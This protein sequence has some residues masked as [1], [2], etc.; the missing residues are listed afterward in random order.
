MG[1]GDLTILIANL[2]YHPPGLTVSPVQE[3]FRWEMLRQEVPALL[4]GCT[5]EQAIEVFTLLR[6]R[7]GRERARLLRDQ[8]CVRVHVP[9]CGSPCMNFWWEA[10][11]FVT[12]IC[13]P[14]KRC[15]WRAKRCIT[16][17][18]CRIL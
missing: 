16:G 11:V 18:L 15:M 1:R 5:E 13:L 9:T 6:Q 7:L 4:Q 2:R 12:T 8:V 17:E 10:W 3:S 14:I